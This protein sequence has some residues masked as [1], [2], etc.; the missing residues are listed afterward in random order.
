MLK[1]LAALLWKRMFLSLTTIN[2]PHGQ[3]WLLSILILAALLLVTGFE[4]SFFEN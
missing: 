4:S 1:S 2:I 3:L